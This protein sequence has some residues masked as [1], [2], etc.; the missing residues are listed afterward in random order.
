MVNFSRRI[1]I[2][3]EGTNNVLVIE[4]QEDEH[5][6]PYCCK[7]MEQNDIP[8]LLRMRHQFMDGVV[9]LRYNIG[10]KVPLREF[11]VR[12]RLTYENG[13]LLL[14]NLS[15]ALLHLNEYFLSVDMCYLDPEQIYVGDGLHVYLPCFPLQQEQV[16]NNSIRLKTFYEKLL[17]EYFATSD[18][19][20][21]DNMFK[22]VY[23][24]TLFDLETF[25]NHFLSETSNDQ[26]KLSPPVMVK[27]AA[28]PKEIINSLTGT[29]QQK[30]N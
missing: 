2:Q 29:V 23:K 19:S 21:Y 10:G 5:L 3:A 8:G 12:N 1:S 14:R 15:S 20:S 16:Q 13:I 24:A 18:C 28:A 11:M 22:W 27:P 4:L 17:S 9:R 26:K 30:E 6:V 7:V 25:Y